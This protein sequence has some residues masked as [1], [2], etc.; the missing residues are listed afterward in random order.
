MEEAARL[1]AEFAAEVA[2]IEGAGERRAARAP[3]Q[4]SW[5]GHALGLRPEARP[6]HPAPPYEAL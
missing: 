6:G 1:R 4:P 3:A 5:P 2:R